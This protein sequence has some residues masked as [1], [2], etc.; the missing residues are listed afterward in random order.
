ML[1]SPATETGSHDHMPRDDA[2]SQAMLRIL[3]TIAG[4]NIG[5]GGRGYID[6]KRRD[7][8][9]LTQEDCSVAEYEAGFL[10]LSSYERGMVAIQCECCVRFEDGLRDS[11]RVL[12]A[13]QR[14]RDFSA[15]VEKAKIAEEVKHV[16]R[17]N[18]DKKRGKN[19][20]DSEPSSSV[21][22]PKNK[23]RSGGPIRVGAPITPTRITLC[24][25]C[26]RRHSGECWR[27][28]EA[29][30]KCRSTEHSVR[31]CLLRANQVQVEGSGTA[32]P[33]GAE[34]R[35]SAL[36]Y[37][38]HRQEDRDAPDV[39]MG[40]FLIF[41]MPYT[42]LIDIGSTHSFVACSISKNLGI[43]VESTSSEVAILNSLGQSVRVSKLYMDVSLEVQGTVF[44]ANLMELP[45]G[46][47]DMILG[48]D[49]LVKHRVSLDCTTKRV[50]LRTEG[51]NEVVVIGER[52]NYLAN[53]ISVL[54]AE[55]LV[56][57]RCEAYLA[58][59]SVSASE[60]S[61]VKD[62]KTVR[63]FLDIFPKEL[64]GLPPNQKV[65]FGIELL[66]GTA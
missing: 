43:P 41:D 28:T 23:V 39:I 61:I 38:F 18:R 32:Q 22:R 56:R 33:P 21:M 57:K 26:G 47:F 54:V 11:L 9:N 40:T 4:P 36:V 44:L 5:P 6:A 2:L 52:Q 66:P 50:V 10:R 63:D 62:I 48:M 25:H 46:E 29:C 65:E 7:F 8:Q 42:V 20:R 49:W 53:V 58:Y 34:A 60:D 15:L 55:K 13:P 17:Q 24:R 35:Q 31:E 19:K 45:F 30:L 12:I 37:A 59:V 14:E 1:V 51:G 16:E 64:P 3:K 27:T